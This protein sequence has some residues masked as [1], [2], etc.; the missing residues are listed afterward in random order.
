MLDI[1]LLLIIFAYMFEGW[2][3]G[4]SLSAFN[5]IGYI[6]SIIISSKF[7]QKLLIFLILNTN[8]LMFLEEKL[9]KWIKGVKNEYILRLF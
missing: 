3:N 7:S 4:L 2:R 1:I 6:L 9:T 5:I 8:I